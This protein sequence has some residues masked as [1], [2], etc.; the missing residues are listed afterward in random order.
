MARR[1]DISHALTRGRA[2]G[3]VPAGIRGPELG[4]ERV[5]G[6]APGAPAPPAPTGHAATRRR[7]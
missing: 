4:R 1:H 7:P 3:D 5:F 6:P 2:H